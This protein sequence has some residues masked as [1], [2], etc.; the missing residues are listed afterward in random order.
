MKIRRGARARVLFSRLSSSPREG[1]PLRFPHRQVAEVA[2]LRAQ[3]KD[4]QKDR[5]SLRNSR[6]RLR[7][8]EQQLGELGD[9]H[10][11]TKTSYARVECDRDELYN[12]FEASIKQIQQK[13]DFANIV[14]EHKLVSM[15]TSV[16]SAQEQVV[17]I[18]SAAGLDANEMENIAFGLQNTLQTRNQNIRETRYELV[19]MTKCYNDALR[20]Y[21]QKLTELGIPNTEIESMGFTQIPTAATAGPAGLVVQ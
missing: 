13:S 8:L 21:N 19:R 5:L 20:T 15:Q 1:T 2:E 3:L 7:V 10:E 11:S 9:S 12:T 18:V 14:L 17:H 16:E 6:A 4:R